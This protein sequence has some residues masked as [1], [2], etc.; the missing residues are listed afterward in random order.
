MCHLD[1]VSAHDGQTAA[2][3]HIIYTTHK[4]GR[5]ILYRQDSVISLASLHRLY[6]ILKFCNIYILY[7]LAKIVM[8]SLMTVSS[9]NTLVYNHRVFIDLQMIHGHKPAHHIR[10]YMCQRNISAL[11]TRSVDKLILSGDKLLYLLLQTVYLFQCIH[12]IYPST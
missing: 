8:H 2:A 11:N 5:G 6:D 10:A 4:S 1:L 3:N 7:I 12:S 9:R